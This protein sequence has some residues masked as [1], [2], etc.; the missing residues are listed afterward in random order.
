M[1][2]SVPEGTT[3]GT[4]V[5]CVCVSDPSVISCAE[6]ADTVCVY[7][8]HGG[9][10]LV[11]TLLHCSLVLFS[12]PEISAFGAEEMRSLLGAASERFS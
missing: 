12:L 9:L 6:Q 4:G 3:S 5:K 11:C 2:S 1:L 7:S 10:C 8:Q